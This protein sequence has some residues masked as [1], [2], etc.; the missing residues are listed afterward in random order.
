[1]KRIEHIFHI[2]SIR[3][4]IQVAFVCISLILFFSGAMSLFELER[5]SRDTE[6]I[7]LASKQNVDIASEM[8]SALNEQNDAMIN[9][10]VIGSRKL[11]D[12]THHSSEC[13]E[14][15]RR[16]SEAATAAHERMLRAENPEATDSLLITANRINELAQSY[17]NGDV[18]SA[19]AETLVIG[20]DTITRISTHTW[21]VETY[22]P[23]YINV[24]R[25]ITRY[26][27]GSE[28]TLGPD[29]NRLSHTAR[30][31]VTPVFISLIVMLVILIM[32]YFF[33]RH[34]YIKPVMRINRSLGDHLTYKMPFDQSIECHD[35]L[36]SLRDK[37]AALTQ[38]NK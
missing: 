11:N 18:H 23:E 6:E 28:S 29:V 1:M 26:M 13:K 38:K 31:T 3:R 5:V 19:I 10:A 33:L 32:F 22:K 4:R 12:I 14:S 36:V 16:L 8:I 7:L 15:I 25:Q 20:N 17:I 21:Y 24:S 34:Y 35:E 9:M 27:T 2:E 37:I 30:R